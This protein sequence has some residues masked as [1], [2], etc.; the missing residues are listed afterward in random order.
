MF[1]FRALVSTGLGRAIALFITERALLVLIQLHPDLTP[2]TILDRVGRVVADHIDKTQL[3]GNPPP[4]I[5]QAIAP[6]GIVHIAA[7]IADQFL[8][9]CRIG[10]G[11]R[12]TAAPTTTTREG[13]RPAKDRSAVTDALIGGKL[14]HI[15]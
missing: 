10:I 15:E 9:E 1:I 4:D 13:R 3:F 14:D 11:T 5:R 6:A 12:A 7:G 8:E 2:S